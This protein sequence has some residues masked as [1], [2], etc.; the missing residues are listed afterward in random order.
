L[1]LF[2]KAAITANGRTRILREIIQALIECG[3]NDYAEQYL[4]RFPPETHSTIDYEASSLLVSD[5]VDTLARVLELGRN[6]FKK[7]I[8]DATV[9]SILI[10]RSAEA[11]QDVFTEELV[12]TAMKKFPDQK[13]NFEQALSEGRAAQQKKTKN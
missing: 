12:Q 7:G 10:R 1:E 4:K 11:G 6:L 13:A 5:K 3:L 2:Q 8:Y 9:L